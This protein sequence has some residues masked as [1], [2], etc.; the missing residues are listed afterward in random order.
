MCIM[1]RSV[2][3]SDN[4]NELDMPDSGAVRKTA[5]HATNAAAVA[6]KDEEPQ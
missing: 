3:E 6:T 4:K 2:E 5:A 1:A